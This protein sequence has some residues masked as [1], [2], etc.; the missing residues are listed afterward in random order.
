MP[1]VPGGRRRTHPRDR[2]SVPQQVF[3]LPETIETLRN[4]ADSGQHG[5]R[6]MTLY[7]HGPAT[8]ALFLFEQTGANLREHST[9]GF[10]TIHTLAGCLTVHAEGQTY[11][12]PAHSLMTL[13]PNVPHD[14][15]ADEPSQM[16][17]TV[18]LEEDDA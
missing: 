17:L 16:L 13:A 7:K 1:Q 2:F 8:V 4:E 9:D 6:Q 11:S 18:C 12:L 3:N 5:H 10:V 15:V 14:V